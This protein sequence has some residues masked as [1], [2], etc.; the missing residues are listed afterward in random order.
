MSGVRIIGNVRGKHGVK[1][2]GVKIR[3]AGPKGTVETTSDSEGIYDVKELPSGRYW[4]H[5]VPTDPYD[6]RDAN[7]Y[8]GD[9]KD[10][11]AWGRDVHLR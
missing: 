6:E 11:E 2:A 5:A 9:V 8:F 4:V 3:I 10:G 7:R 1:L